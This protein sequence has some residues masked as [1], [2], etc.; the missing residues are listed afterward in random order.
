MFLVLPFAV[1]VK[2]R[3]ATSELIGFCMAATLFTMAS[4]IA[5][6][7]HFNVLLPGYVV[8]IKAAFDRW[9]GGRLYFSLFLVGVSAVLVGYPIVPASAVTD[10]ARNLLQSHVLFGACILVG[11]FLR[12]AFVVPR[13]AKTV[14]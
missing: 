7:H 13:Q 14:A 4:P 11:I 5:W 12:E 9:R 10:P 6:V 2:G 1:T 3:D 8:A